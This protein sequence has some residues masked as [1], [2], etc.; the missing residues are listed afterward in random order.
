M[1]EAV[2]PPRA[3]RPQGRPR[4]AAKAAAILEAA[5][6][7]FLEYGFDAVT[8]EGVAQRAGVS[9]V[10]VYARHANKERL[11]QAV[12]ARER[13]KAAG[14]ILAEVAGG[15]DLR[16]ALAAFGR[17][18]VRLTLGADMMAVD[19]LIIS[20]AHRH[21]A[22]SRMFYEAGPLRMR[23]SLVDLLRARAPMAQDAAER[24]ARD[25][26]ALLSGPRNLALRIGTADAVAEYGDLDAYA[27]RCADVAAAAFPR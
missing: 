22:L 17:A 18:F 19:R 5:R 24:F 15:S 26:I 13:E 6:A 27:D 20:Q 21:P 10:T 1:H 14:G 11:F 2:A 7:L 4:D 12:V 23:A 25:F 8:I 3:T 9:K 16:G